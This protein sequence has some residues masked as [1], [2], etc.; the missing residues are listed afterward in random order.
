MGQCFSHWGGRQL[1]SSDGHHHAAQHVG[2]GAQQVLARQAAG[3]LYV[4]RRFEAQRFGHLGR[5]LAVGLGDLA[6]QFDQ[7]L[8]GQRRTGQRDQ[9]Q[10]GDNGA[11]GQDAVQLDIF[12]EVNAL[13]HPTLFVGIVTQHRHQEQHRA[14][15]NHQRGW[16]GAGVVQAGSQQHA[17][18]RNAQQGIL[19]AKGVPAGPGGHQPQAQ[20]PGQP[21]GQWVIAG[22]ACE[23]TAQ[24]G[25]QAAE[26][27]AQAG[28]Q[29]VPGQ[30]Q[31]G[32][33]RGA[34]WPAQQVPQPG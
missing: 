9:H 19:A 1:A 34:F 31:G 25:A 5:V 16:A 26:Q 13:G 22:L 11:G 23:Q 14:N 6:P 32:V 33:W 10:A 4:R 30:Q 7:C 29:L 24:P 2:R 21:R 28:K 3:S 20:D 15:Q 18:R 17:G 27:R 12:G 8:P